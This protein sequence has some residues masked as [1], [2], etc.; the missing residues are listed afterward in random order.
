MTAG[1]PDGSTM[2]F[3][4][5]ATLQLPGLTK[6]AIQIIIFTETITVPLISLGVSYVMMDALSH[7]TNKELQSKIMDNK[8][9]K[10][11]GTNK[12]EFGKIP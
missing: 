2:D 5:V 7:Y 11:P 12:Q 8:Y 1:L 3:S 10:K 4:H 6:K 9:E